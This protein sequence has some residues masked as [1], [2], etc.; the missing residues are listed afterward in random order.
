MFNDEYQVPIAHSVFKQSVNNVI[1]HQLQQPTIESVAN[2]LINK[3]VKQI[4]LY[5]RQNGH[6][7]QHDVGQL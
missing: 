4:I 5:R 1:A 3:F 7:A 2:C 6:A